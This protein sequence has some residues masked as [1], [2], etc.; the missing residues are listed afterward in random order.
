MSLS[1]QSPSFE[2][3]DHFELQSRR[4]P[5]RFDANAEDN[6]D[7]DDGNDAHSPSQKQFRILLTSTGKISSPARPIS[8]NRV[9]VDRVRVDRVRVDR[10]RVDRVRVDQVQEDPVRKAQICKSVFATYDVAL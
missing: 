4:L 7:D 2:I 6:N 8:Y 5:I 9:R 1:F 3:T 10:V